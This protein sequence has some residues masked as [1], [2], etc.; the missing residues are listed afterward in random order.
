MN[1]K[2]LTAVLVA[3]VGLLGTPSFS[4]G[5]NAKHIDWQRMTRDLEI[6]E[7]VLDQ[8]L[9]GSYSRWGFERGTTRGVYFAGYGVVFQVNLS[10]LRF[11][12]AVTATQRAAKVRKK[13]D[14]ETQVV[15]VAP[16]AE[17]TVELDENR[18]KQIA[19]MKEQIVTFLGDYA[20]AI[21]QLSPSERITVV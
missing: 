18:E 21:R 5:Q 14:E 4:P 10:S 8:L 3:V 15:V 11:F 1:R 13:Q 16:D 20:D 12:T 7:G 17:G 6:M 9:D 2:M 19:D